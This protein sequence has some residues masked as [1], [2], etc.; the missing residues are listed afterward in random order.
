[1]DALLD[2][3]VFCVGS[4]EY[5]WD[6]VILAAKLRGDWAT[7]EKEL[8]EGLACVKRMDEAEGEF[9]AGEL[10]SAANDFRYERDLVT[11]E[12]A[13]AWL[14][15]WDL[16]AEAW[17]D[18]IRRCVLR[19]KWA[20]ELAEVV[21]RFPVTQREI[22]DCLRAEAVCSG[23]LARFA[24]ALAAWASAFE[25]AREEGWTHEAAPCAKRIKRIDQLEVGYRSFRAHV[26]DPHGLKYQ[27]GWHR[28]D[29]IRFE[30][31]FAMFPHKEMAREAALCVRDDGMR[32]EDVAVRARIGVQNVL[33]YLEEIDPSV[34][35]RFLSAGKGALVGPLDWDKGFALFVVEDKILPALDDPA[36]R[37][38]AEESLIQ[39]AI[40][41]EIANRVK[42]HVQ[43]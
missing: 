14:K 19:R 26:V 28:L 37:R 38:R 5:R 3:L 20:D 22:N 27:V 36:I 25:N 6:D 30:C 42:W 15:Q 1:M 7:L 21:A 10:E 32:L 24:Q 18:Y 2:E 16:S 13:E 12:E 43:L 41:R 23:Y 34:R 9:D 17:I 40:N 8:Y 35:E 4:E 39:D 33:I 31:R 11:A 29:W